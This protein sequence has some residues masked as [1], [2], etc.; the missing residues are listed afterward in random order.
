MYAVLKVVSAQ[1]VNTD[2]DQPTHRD[3]DNKK[4][5]IANN[6]R[7]F[8]CTT[9]QGARISGARPPWCLLFVGTQ[10]GGSFRPLE[11]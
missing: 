3:G 6:E 11:F 4:Q 7:R 5:K 2:I 1:T 8:S 10:F 9:T